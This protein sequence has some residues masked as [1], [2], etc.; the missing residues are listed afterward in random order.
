MQRENTPLAHNTGVSRTSAF[1]PHKRISTANLQGNTKMT[2]TK[3]P[4][5][6]L[7]SGHA[8]INTP[9]NRVLCRSP[10]CSRAVMPFSPEG[11][12]SIFSLPCNGGNGRNA[13]NNNY[14]EKKNYCTTT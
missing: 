8:T 14:P 7:H 9:E 11:L 2:Q 6:A 12:L 5:H 13:K 10:H 3:I 4:P 1:K